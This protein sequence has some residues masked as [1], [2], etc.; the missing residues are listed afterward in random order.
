ML[1]SKTLL[2]SDV[3]KLSIYGKSCI[4]SY[5]KKWLFFAV[6]EL[7]KII[8]RETGLYE[9]IKWNSEDRK[10]GPKHAKIAKEGGISVYPFS[11]ITGWMSDQYFQL[12]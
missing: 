2:F 1:Q 4:S 9:L 6:Y 12:N 3:N 11:L 8:F 10:T 7:I 5:S